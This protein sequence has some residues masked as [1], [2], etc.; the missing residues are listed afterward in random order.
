MSLVSARH[1]TDAFFAPVRNPESSRVGINPP[2]K[3]DCLLLV[4]SANPSLPG[5]RSSLL[6]VAPGLADLVAYRLHLVTL[7]ALRS[8][9]RHASS[10]LH[11]RWGLNTDYAFDQNANVY[12]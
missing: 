9:L 10:Y 4:K 8:L 1:L 7:L 3:V 6:R 12:F 2:T 11:V 5:S